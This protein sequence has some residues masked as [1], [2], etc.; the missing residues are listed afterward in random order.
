MS[1]LVSKGTTDQRSKLIVTDKSR[2]MVSAMRRLSNG[3][4]DISFSGAFQ[5]RATIKIGDDY[6]FDN[7]EH[8]FEFDIQF[9]EKLGEKVSEIKLYNVPRDV[10]IKT[11][12][13][14]TVKAGYDTQLRVILSGTITNVKTKWDELDRVTTIKAID[15]PSLWERMFHYTYTAGCTASFILKDLIH[16][17]KQ[18]L[19]TFEVGRDQT[20]EDEETIDGSLNKNINRLAS[21]C[22][23]AIY[24]NG[25]V[26]VRKYD[27]IKENDTCVGTMSYLNG[28]LDFNEWESRESYGVNHIYKHGYDITMLLN[29]RMGVITV[30][31][32][33]K[34]ETLSEA[35]YNNEND[36]G[37][38][39]IAI[40]G[41]HE[42]DGEKMI[43]KVRGLI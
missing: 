37:Q 42:Y 28:V 14:I 2:E 9:G 4:S 8:D 22:N 15:Y 3:I 10:K 36:I 26:C 6:L 1:N 13:S 16:Q 24:Y 38:K 40:S 29:N 12:M 7:N 25:G 27:S 23:A 41:S 17:T 33:N 39:M 5:Q 31:K 32:L 18:Q 43:T 20:Y 21:V 11:D 19:F 34:G 35:E 30:F